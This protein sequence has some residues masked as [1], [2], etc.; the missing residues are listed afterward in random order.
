MI[1][2]RGRKKIAL[3]HCRLVSEGDLEGLLALYAPEATFE[4]PVGAGRQTGHEALRAHFGSALAANV[5]E[6][7]EDP[8]AGQD[9][10]HVIMPVTA[11]MDYRPRGPVYV[12]RGWLP[13]PEGAEPSGLRCQYMLLL[14]VGESGLIEDM[15][16]FWG[17][18]DIEAVG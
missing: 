15:Q 12:E 4:D 7:A 10:M 1:N 18:G 3:E 13:G 14:R 8:A 5:K 11:T 16:A 17:R 2:E 6:I 9:G